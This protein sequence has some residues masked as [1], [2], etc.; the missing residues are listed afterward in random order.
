MMIMININDAVVTTYVT[1]VASPAIDLT[2]ITITILSSPAQW[3]IN[4]FYKYNF[5]KMFAFVYF[6]KCVAIYVKHL[7]S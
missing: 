6:V 1:A 4:I 7:K 2:T 5:L 3:S